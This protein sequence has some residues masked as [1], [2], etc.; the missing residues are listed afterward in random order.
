MRILDMHCDTIERLY[1]ENMTEDLC[2]NSLQL[3][4]EKM[5]AG[6]YLLQNFAVFIDAGRTEDTFEE[7]QGMIDLYYREMEKNRDRISPV[8]C[9][10]DIQT[11]CKQGKMSALLTIEGGEALKGRLEA[12]EHFYER[13]VR[14]VTL[15][16][17]YEN[18]L[19]FPNLVRA[20]DGTPLL[21]HRNKRG[22]KAF[23]IAAVQKMENLG[24]IIDV[25]HL[26][27]G[28]FFDVARY[29]EKPFVASHS[30]AASLCPVSRNLTDEMIRIL[31]E[32]G[33]VM[34]LNF[35]AAF[36][37][38]ADQRRPES[39]IE[40]MVR[41]IRHITDVGG[42]DVCAL[43]SDYD[44]IPCC[45]DM[46]DASCIQQL[47]EALMH[48]GFSQDEIEKIC[49]RNALRLYREILG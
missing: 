28:G 17:N 30:N 38:S 11:N 44:G 24:M 8:L 27:D 21:D 37:Q 29:T 43:G 5:E 1:H 2:R 49:F 16:W 46:P 3:D 34:G 26:S 14:L 22:L 7:A 48:S 45:D 6:E 20:K 18:E 35:C 31:A 47:V 13:G 9:F 15:T 41:Q 33:G 10:R 40:D 42:T 19:G 12:L 36:L 25:S 4:L 39:R 23:G 32:R